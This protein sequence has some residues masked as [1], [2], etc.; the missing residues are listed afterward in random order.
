MPV[1]LI[2]RLARRMPRLAK[3]IGLG[4][5]HYAEVQQAM[6]KAEAA[7]AVA[8][9]NGNPAETHDAQGKPWVLMR[10]TLRYRVTV[11]PKLNLTRQSQ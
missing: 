1:R 6:Q 8:L 5:G 10:D 7:E 2:W 9:I 11:S 3:S 4:L